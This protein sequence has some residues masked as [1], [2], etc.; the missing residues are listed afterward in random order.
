VGSLVDDLELEHDP[1]SRT[2]T[3]RAQRTIA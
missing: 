2:T 1:R 3:V